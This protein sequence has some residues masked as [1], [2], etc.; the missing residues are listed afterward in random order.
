M[1]LRKMSKI[2]EAKVRQTNNIT[3]EREGEE[4][5]IYIVRVGEDV[6]LSFEL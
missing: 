2:N 3:R 5:A 4:G 1:G 6:T